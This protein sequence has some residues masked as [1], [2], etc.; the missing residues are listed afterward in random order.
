MECGCKTLKKTVHDRDTLLSDNNVK[1]DNAFTGKTVD[2]VDNFVNNLLSVKKNVDKNILTHS[3]I[4]KV[5]IEGITPDAAKPIRS[6]PRM[7]GPTQDHN[8]GAR[9]VARSIPV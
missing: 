9:A 3:I 8:P 1:N 4:Q 7:S 6:H 5:S 2:N